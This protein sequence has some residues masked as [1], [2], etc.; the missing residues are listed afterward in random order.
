MVCRTYP[1]G[2]LSCGPFVGSRVTSRRDFKPKGLHAEMETLQAPQIAIFSLA[3]VK[4][5]I[6]YHF[7]ATMSLGGS[8]I[9]F[10]MPVNSNLWKR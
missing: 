1:V 10:S 3:S 2:G 5:I 7:H 4:N 8:Q 9:I 6:L